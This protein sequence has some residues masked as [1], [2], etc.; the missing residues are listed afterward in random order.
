MADP[1]IEKNEQEIENTGNL[2]QG[3]S[4]LS[5]ADVENVAGGGHH[6]TLASGSSSCG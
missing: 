3:E 1:N 6:N 4:E 2:N 5:D